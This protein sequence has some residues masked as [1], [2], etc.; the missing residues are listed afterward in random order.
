MKEDGIMRHRQACTLIELLIVVAII[1]IL[2]AIAVPNFLE[3]QTRAKVSTAYSDIRTIKVALEMY[4]LDNGRYLPDWGGTH[5]AVDWALLTTPVAY[6]TQI[7]NSPFKTKGTDHTQ[8]GTAIGDP[9]W[10]GVFGPNP[11]GLMYEIGCAGPDLDCDWILLGN[12]IY[13]LDAGTGGTDLLY[14]TTNGTKSSGDI[15]ATNKR[16]YNA[17]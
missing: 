14:D 2:A 9:Y 13:E 12:P 17:R 1:A 6:L 4:R 15:I 11:Q 8:Y 3:A 10:Y 16:T 5:E 7:Y